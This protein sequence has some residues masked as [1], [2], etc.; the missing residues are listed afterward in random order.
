MSRLL[1]VLSPLS[2]ASIIYLLHILAR[3]SE[4]LGTVTR[5]AP[6]YR[7]FRVG[8]V[9]L[10]VALVTQFLR[11]S[12]LLGQGYGAAWWG[13]PMFFLLTYYLPMA[14]GVTIGLIITCRYW[15][16]LLTEKD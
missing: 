8:Q 7:W 14:A 4:K 2:I 1:V 3:L 9:L 16:W 13:S 15:M 10:A 6:Y 12:L 11:V 5:M